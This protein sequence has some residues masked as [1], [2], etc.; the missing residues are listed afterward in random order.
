VN[1]GLYQEIGSVWTELASATFTG[2]FSGYSTRDTYAYQPV[3][4][5]LAAGGIY[6]IVA[7]GY[8]TAANPYITGHTTFN[9]LDGTVSAG[10][11]TKVGAS[12]PGTFSSPTFDGNMYG[13]GTFAVVPEATDFALAAVALLGLVYVGRLYSQKLKLA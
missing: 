11:L 1:V 8:G 7:S 2:L 6:A 10:G 3:N 5:T 4:L 13:A 9:A 12:L